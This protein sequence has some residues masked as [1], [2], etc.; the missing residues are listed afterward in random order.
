[1]FSCVDSGGVL[2]ACWCCVSCVC[3]TIDLCFRTC[4]VFLRVS[5]SSASSQGAELALEQHR[6][7]HGHTVLV[8]TKN[9]F[10]LSPVCVPLDSL[11]LS[12]YKSRRALI[13]THA[14]SDEPVPATCGCIQVDVRV[15]RS[16]AQK[17]DRLKQGQQKGGKEESCTFRDTGRDFTMVRSS[18]QHRFC[19]CLSFC[20]C[21]SFTLC[22]QQRWFKCNTCWPA[23]DAGEG[24]CVVCASVCHAGH[25]LVE[26]VLYFW[27]CATE[28]VRLQCG[29]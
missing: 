27:G 1:L 3:S 26:Q 28:F 4:N 11:C 18:V 25:K 29:L 19:V 13:I 21:I 16:K 20:G 8:L 23:E 22:L 9:G 2:L 15:E 5:S 10:V 12:L 7:D 17:Q 6:K 14:H 24:V